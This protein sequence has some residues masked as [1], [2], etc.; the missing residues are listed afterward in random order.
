M[1]KIELT[2]LHITDGVW[3]GLLRGWPGD[4][5]PELCAFRG[6]MALPAPDAT[7]QGGDWQVTLTVPSS[8]IS[9]GMQIFTITT[10]TG[11]VLAEFA[12][13]SGRA[14]ETNLRAEVALLRAELDMLKRVVRQHL[15]DADT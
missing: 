4:V 9:G 7:A 12:V 10:T 8:A 15:R 6:E 5:P 14:V 13:Q 3:H 2:E 1:Q 11:D